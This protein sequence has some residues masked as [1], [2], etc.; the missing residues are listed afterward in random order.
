MDELSI[1]PY[2][3]VALMALSITLFGLVLELV[4][5]DFL[6]EKYALLWLGTASAGLV[7]GL[8]PSLIV[9]LTRL[10]QF[11]MIT[12]LFVLSFLY[13]LGIILAFSVVISRLA[14][15][16]R[17]LSQEVGLLMHR[18]ERLERPDGSA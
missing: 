15:R 8:F 12:T 10:L 16:N 1:Q 2:H 4:R 13:T 7:I 14:E 3:Q 17:R 6:K 9:V 18:V 11:Q 5:R